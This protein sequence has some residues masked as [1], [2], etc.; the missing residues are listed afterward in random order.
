[1]APLPI[2]I[3]VACAVLFFRAATY[4]RMS[5]WAWAISSLALTAL[6]AGFGVLAML[7]AQVV[8]FGVLWWVNA[9]R[10]RDPVP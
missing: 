10:K 6:T 3:G 1:M 8:L 7:L 2:L 9:T 5:G 4:E